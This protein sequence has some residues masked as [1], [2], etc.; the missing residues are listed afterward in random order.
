MVIS[1]ITCYFFNIRVLGIFA[2]SHIFSQ[3]VFPSLFTALLVFYVSMEKKLSAAKRTECHISISFAFSVPVA[4]SERIA[5]TVT[6]FAISN[7]KSAALQTV[8]PVIFR[9]HERIK[10]N[11]ARERKTST[12][13]FSRIE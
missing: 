1:N 2:Q 4:K 9:G 5:T 13:A 6:K 11:N 10:K 8:R 12:K 7:R 3:K